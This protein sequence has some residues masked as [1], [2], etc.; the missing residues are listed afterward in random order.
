MA[1]FS[2]DFKMTKIE[3]RV[4]IVTLLVI[5]LLSFFNLRN[6]EVLARDIQRK[7]DLKHVATALGEFFKKYGEYPQAL[8]GKM[9]ACGTPPDLKPCRWAADKIE[10]IMDLI[11]Q[12]PLASS[13]EY[14][15]L[16]F[17]NSREFQLFAHL[18]RKQDEE[19]NESVA[20]RKLNCG[21]VECN[22][23]V[24]NGNI[25]LDRELSVFKVNEATKSSL[26]NE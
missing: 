25:P 20:Q 3:S 23:G 7:N 12:D 5:G 14:S 9:V 22:F 11:P 13:K 4:V 16:Y 10:G 6:A 18:E 19:Y 17:S 15:Y 26:L 2:K 24:V 1:I 21:K 8:D